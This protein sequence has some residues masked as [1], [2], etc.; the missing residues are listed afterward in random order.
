MFIIF[1]D[2]KEINFQ[3]DLMIKIIKTKK[4]KIQKKKIK[5]KSKKK[6][7]S[8]IRE[9]KRNCFMLLYYPQNLFLFSM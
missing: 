5:P 2:I 8:F 3:T 6:I 9:R 1:N 7:L 4:K